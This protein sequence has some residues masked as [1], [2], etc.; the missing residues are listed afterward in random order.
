[1][2][3]YYTYIRRGSL[4]SCRVIPQYANLSKQTVTMVTNI[5]LNQLYELHITIIS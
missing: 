5:I 4:P 2:T 3:C 1:M